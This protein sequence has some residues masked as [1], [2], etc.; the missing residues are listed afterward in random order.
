MEILGLQPG[1]GEAWRGEFGLHKHVALAL[2]RG[3]IVE[4]EVKMPTNNNSETLSSEENYK[5][6]GILEADNTKHTPVKKNTTKQ[7]YQRGKNTL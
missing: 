3:K 1:K 5:Y 2:N 7:H 4:Q 6:F